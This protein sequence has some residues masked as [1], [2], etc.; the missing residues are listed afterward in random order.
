MKEG[1]GVVI[2]HD[3]Q[4]NPKQEEEARESVGEPLYFSTMLSERDLEAV[5]PAES[6]R[7]G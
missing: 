6:E 1:D 3:H 7:A 4:L 2:L 5:E